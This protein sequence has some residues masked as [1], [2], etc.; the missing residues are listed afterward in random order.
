[1][2]RTALIQLIILAQAATLAI[3]LLSTSAPLTAAF[4]QYKSEMLY[5]AIKGG[6]GTSLAWSVF[7]TAVPGLMLRLA[8]ASGIFWWL[9]Q[10]RRITE[11][12]DA[13]AVLV[14]RRIVLTVAACLLVVLT[15]VALVF[16]AHAPKPVPDLVKEFEEKDIKK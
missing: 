16:R 13:S 7:F 15:V 4:A 3:F 10:Q 11:S 8:A 6:S 2:K 14:S 5:A 1:M 12:A 9:F